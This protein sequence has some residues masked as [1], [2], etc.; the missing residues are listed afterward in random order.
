MTAT[1]DPYILFYLFSFFFDAVAV[2]GVA[3]LLHVTVHRS[4]GPPPAEFLH[5]S[6]NISKLFQCCARLCG[7][8][9][10]EQEMEWGGS[11]GECQSSSVLSHPL[12]LDS[13]H[14]LFNSSTVTVS[15]LFPTRLLSLLS[16]HLFPR[17]TV[18]ICK[19]SVV[20]PLPL[21]SL[22]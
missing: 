19:S 8:G 22:Q 16:M 9:G 18:G 3:E 21:H 4:I 10:R 13:S 7:G 6:L 15:L 20:S 12:S 11:W 1:N 5:V 2:G 14:F 17:A